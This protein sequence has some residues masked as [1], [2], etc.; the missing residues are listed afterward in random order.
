[1]VAELLLPL[2]LMVDTALGGTVPPKPCGVP[3]SVWV[4]EAVFSLPDWVMNESLPKT[5]S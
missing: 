1:M 3:S 5:P 2:W 4:T